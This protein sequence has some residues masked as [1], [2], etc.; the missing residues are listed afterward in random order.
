MGTANLPRAAASDF[1]GLRKA[2]NFMLS[3]V[4]EQNP[5][6]VPDVHFKCITLT[7]LKRLIDSANVVD[8][9]SF[10]SAMK[11]F[12]SLIQVTHAFR[13]FT[14]EDFRRTQSVA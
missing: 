2:L 7:A 5:L 4:T 12:D 9:S 11:V 1:I 6:K 8:S 13:S 10:N 3:L 14:Q